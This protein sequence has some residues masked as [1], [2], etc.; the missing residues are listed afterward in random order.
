MYRSRAIWVKDALVRWLMAK[1]SLWVHWLLAAYLWLVSL[2]SLGRW[3]AQPEP[4]LVAAL[5]AGQSLTRGDAAF[6]GFVALPA[7]LFTLAVLRRSRLAAASA[8]ICDLIWLA[9]QIL[10]WWIPYI[11]GTA[12]PWQVRYGKGPTTKILPSFGLHV[13]PDAMHLLITILIVAALWTGLETL[14]TRSLT[15]LTT[16]GKSYK[17]ES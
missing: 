4:H 15:R 10:S 14:R 17:R 1:I 13:A 16:S 8:L 7:L 11:F 9:L 12:K 2:V 5:R 3:N 6:L